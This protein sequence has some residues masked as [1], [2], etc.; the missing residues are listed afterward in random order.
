VNISGP[1]IQ[2]RSGIYFNLLNP[3][4]EDVRI[5]DIAHALA[6][7]CRFGG[8]TREFYSVAQHSCLVAALVPDHLKLHALLHDAAEAYC[9][10]M[11]SPLKMCVPGYV[12]IQKRIEAAVAERFNIPHE[13][14]AEIK[15]A[16]LVALATERR[17][18]MPDC[19]HKWDCLDG[20][21]PHPMPEI[22]MR[23]SY[24]REIFLA[25]AELFQTRNPNPR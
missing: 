10:D 13:L 5:E 21:E 11:I 19:P 17:D 16:D 2:T 14:P 15:R 4:P 22:P 3:R 23:P 8:H 24:A 20:V 18:L 1:V 7:L 9:G 6:N 25:M 12:T